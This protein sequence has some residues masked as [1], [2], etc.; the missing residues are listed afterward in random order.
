M[1]FTTKEIVKKHILDHHIGSAKIYDEKIQLNANDSSQLE[2]RMILPE[3]ERVKAR[4]QNEPNEENISF[5]SSDSVALSHNQ[6]IPNTVVAANNSSL[7]KIYIENIDFQIDYIQGTIMRI[8]SGSIP[9]AG[10]IVVWYLNY[11]IYQRGSDYDIEYQ[12]GT[13]KRRSGGAIESG[14]W[15]QVDYT[16]EY[17]NLDDASIE[18]AIAEANDQVL[19]F[20]D[21]VYRESADRLL[22][23]AETYMSVAI[24]C[25][26][27]AMESISPSRGKTDGGNEARSWTALSDMYKKE[28][29]N[30]LSKFAGRLGSF[31]SPASA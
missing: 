10:S 29:Y 9:A 21:E 23:T 6:I 14:Q 30:I 2:K 5:A 3:S 13:L 12:A 15:V 19:S 31:N 7:S 18:N 27:R 17:G 4:E 11:R 25:R 28:A 16:T 8:A 1:P 24:I 26:I 22:V 20:I